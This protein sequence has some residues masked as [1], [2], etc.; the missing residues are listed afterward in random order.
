MYGVRHGLHVVPRQAG[1]QADRHSQGA[2]TG[3]A[4]L[5]AVYLSVSTAGLA[6]SHTMP[7]V[8]TVVGLCADAEIQT[9]HALFFCVLEVLL[10]NLLLPV[11]WP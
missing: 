11:G 2:E 9:A 7:D 10:C 4:C 1:R 5:A 6:V 8:T 3:P